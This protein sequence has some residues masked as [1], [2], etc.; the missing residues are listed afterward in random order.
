MPSPAGPSAATSPAEP[1]QPSP[2][3]IPLQRKPPASGARS[4]RQGVSTSSAENGATPFQ[5]I[6]ATDAGY[7]AVPRRSIIEEPPPLLFV[8]DG[9]PQDPP[10]VSSV[11][12][13]AGLEGLEDL[14][15]KAFAR[16]MG[17]LDSGSLEQVIADALGNGQASN[18]ADSTLD[19]VGVDDLRCK[20][21][22]RIVD[23]LSTGHLEKAM[24]EAIGKTTSKEEM[25]DRLKEQVEMLT[26]TLA[27]LA[28]ENQFLRKENAALRSRA[29]A[30]E[31]TGSAGSALQA[32]RA[33]QKDEGT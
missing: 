11:N 8:A 3:V 20:A 29:G 7:A 27:Q 14:R 5:E 32:I 16:F 13:D 12:D 30:D 24:S 19:D 21:F 26:T 4:I 10:I 18:S 23:A 1:L 17:A 25:I 33:S 6:A 22:S 28:H 31:Q 15:A 2:P 9:Q